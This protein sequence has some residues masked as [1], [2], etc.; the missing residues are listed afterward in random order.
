MIFRNSISRLARRCR[1]LRTCKYSSSVYGEGDRSGISVIARCGLR[2]TQDQRELGAVDVGDLVDK[3]GGE[4]LHE[5]R[6]IVSIRER[7]RWMRGHMV[8]V[9]LKFMTRNVAAPNADPIYTSGYL[10]FC[11]ARVVR[12]SLLRH[13]GVSEF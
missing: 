11:L 3:V 7:R 5:A 2:E 4:E 12:M 10:R 13:F 8:L 1:A 6:R 9:I